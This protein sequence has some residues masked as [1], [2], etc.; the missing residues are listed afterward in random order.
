MAGIV[1][2]MKELKVTGRCA[3]GAIL[4]W[5][6]APAAC[7]RKQARSAQARHEITDHRNWLSV[8]AAVTAIGLAVPASRSCQ[9]LPVRNF[10]LPGCGD[11]HGPVGAHKFI[12][13]LLF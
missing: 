9:Q 7:D 13:S 8:R 4:G 2:M 11:S 12:Q 1:L 10:M 3:M 6:A 5:R